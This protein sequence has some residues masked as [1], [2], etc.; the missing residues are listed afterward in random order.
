MARVRSLVGKVKHYHKK[1]QFAW[2]PRPSDRNTFRGYIEGQLAATPGKLSYPYSDT[3]ASTRQRSSLVSDTVHKITTGWV[4]LFLNEEDFHFFLQRVC[5]A[6]STAVLRRKLLRYLPEVE[7]WQSFKC[8]LRLH[9]VVSASQAVHRFKIIDQ[10]G[11]F[12]LNCFAQKRW[13]Q[14]GSRSNGKYR[15][16][17]AEA[18]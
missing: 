13:K 5:G 6:S 15:V 10:L 16:R 1:V 17:T 3:C 9:Q 7:Y 4:N 8:S 11:T 18:A 2:T 14:G 12:R